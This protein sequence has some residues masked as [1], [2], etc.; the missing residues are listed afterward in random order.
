MASWWCIHLYG[1]KSV[2]RFKTFSLL[3]NINRLYCGLSVL[4]IKNRMNESIVLFGCCA[5]AGEDQWGAA[6]EG[7]AEGQQWKIGKQVRSIPYVLIIEGLFLTCFIWKWLHA[8]AH[9]NL[10]AVPEVLNCLYPTSFGWVWKAC[11][12]AKETAKISPFIIVKN[13]RNRICCWISQ[14]PMVV[15]WIM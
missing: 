11:F 10:V 8:V 4:E 15:E 6:G 9:Q 3:D 14:F 5:A 2:C 12:L 7:P 1:F 13:F